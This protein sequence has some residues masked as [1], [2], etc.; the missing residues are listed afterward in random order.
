MWWWLRDV[1]GASHR[2]RIC[3]G[4][5]GSFHAR[6]GNLDRALGTSLLIAAHATVTH[7]IVSFNAQAHGIAKRTSS[8]SPM[9]NGARTK[10]M[11]MAAVVWISAL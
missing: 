1:D 2:H 6:N 3:T 5:S 4:F 10:F 11:I 7:G 9:N 8:H